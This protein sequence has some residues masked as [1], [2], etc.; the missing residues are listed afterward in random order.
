MRTRSSGAVCSRPPENTAAN[1]SKINDGAS[2][3][4]LATEAAVK[5]LGGKPIA[6]ILA[7]AT[8]SQE[9]EWFTTAP[10]MATRKAVE[11]AGLSL[12]QIDLFDVNEAFAVV[13]MAYLKDL[14]LDPNKVNVNGGAVALGHPIGSSG[15]R[16]LATLSHALRARRKKIGL[17]S[18]CIGGGEGT[19]LI[20]EAL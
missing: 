18:I 8:H 11:K 10:V 5:E 12:S 15:S 19:G 16:I 9:P 17:A 1:A 14:E 13:A 2:A 4:V 6:R 3:L 7:Y 20:V